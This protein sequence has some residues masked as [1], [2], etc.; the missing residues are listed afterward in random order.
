MASGTT[1]RAAAAQEAEL[2][3]G[4]LQLLPPMWPTPS[5]SLLAV[6]ETAELEALLLFPALDLR[7]FP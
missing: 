7:R 2:A 4:Y 1:T 6:L 5:R 3:H